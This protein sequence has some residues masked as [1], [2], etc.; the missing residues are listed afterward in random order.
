M[1]HDCQKCGKHESGNWVED[2]AKKLV[3]KQ[4]CFTCNYWSELLGA[5]RSVIVNGVHHMDGGQTSSPFKGF[6]GAKFVYEK[7][8]ERHETN[9]MWFQGEVPAVWRSEFPDNAT[10]VKEEA[11]ANEGPF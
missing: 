10:W 6:G 5:K 7:N 2:C 4:F 9:N 8:G 1:N 3:A 11:K